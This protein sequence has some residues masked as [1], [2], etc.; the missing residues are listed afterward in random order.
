M[1]DV[2]KVAVMLGL[3]ATTMCVDR[4]NNAKPFW[5]AMYGASAGCVASVIVHES[6]S[7]VIWVYITIVYASVIISNQ[8]G[9]Q[10]SFENAI[11][12]FLLIVGWLLSS[13]LVFASDKE[14]Q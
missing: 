6:A 13:W 9:S 11:K 7:Y 10:M 5:Y 12:T 3:I 2:V 8:I 4:K 1:Q 14:I